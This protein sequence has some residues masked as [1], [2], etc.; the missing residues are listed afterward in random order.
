MNHLAQPLM[1]WLGVVVLYRFPL[2]GSKI[3]ERVS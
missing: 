3:R 2:D 1:L